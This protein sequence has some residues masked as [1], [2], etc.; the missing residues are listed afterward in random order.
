[1]D[2]KHWKDG[3]LIGAGL[4]SLGKAGGKPSFG[5][6]R[7]CIKNG[8]NQE[9][10]KEIITVNIRNV[11]TLS[12]QDLEDIGN[13]SKGLMGQAQ[14]IKKKGKRSMPVKGDCP[15]CPKK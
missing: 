1:M 3:K 8:D 10:V 9:P 6:C 12:D 4:C 14:S 13:V 15:K 11:H 2:C 5:F 7:R